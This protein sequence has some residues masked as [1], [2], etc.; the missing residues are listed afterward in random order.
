MQNPSRLQAG[1]ASAAD[2]ERGGARPTCCLMTATSSL[3]V[4]AWSH[5][6]FSSASRVAAASFALFRLALQSAASA[7]E[8]LSSSACNN[9]RGEAECPEGQPED[10]WG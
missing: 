8:A 9:V 3:Q 5:I 10:I 1:G 4:K 7:F 2:S 6:P